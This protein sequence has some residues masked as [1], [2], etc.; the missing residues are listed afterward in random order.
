MTEKA[1]QTSTARR[2]SLA[3]ARATQV[4][5]FSSDVVATRSLKPLF[6]FRRPADVSSRRLSLYLWGRRSPLRLAMASS[7]ARS[8]GRQP[9]LTLVVRL[10]VFRHMRRPC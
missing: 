1:P 7:L 10:C 2:W 3:V 8:S 9:D 4:A 5:T 6:R